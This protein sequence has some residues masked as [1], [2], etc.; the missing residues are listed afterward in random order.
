MAIPNSPM[1]RFLRR[2]FP[3]AFKVMRSVWTDVIRNIR[4][5]TPSVT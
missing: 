5:W 1:V 3:S 2:V 4:I